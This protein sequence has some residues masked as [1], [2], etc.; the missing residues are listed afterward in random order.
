MLDVTT[1]RAVL[2]FNVDVDYCSIT[3]LSSKHWTGCTEKV[4][5]VYESTSLPDLY[6]AFKLGINLELPY[7]ST[8]E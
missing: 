7:L 4:L 2:Q 8:R 3:A 1:L 6:E 5:D